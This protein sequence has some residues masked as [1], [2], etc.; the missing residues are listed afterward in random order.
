MEGPQTALSWTCMCVA[1]SVL[2]PFLN[3]GFIDDWNTRKMCSDGCWPLLQFI[4]FSLP[5]TQGELISVCVLHFD[6][7]WQDGAMGDLLHMA[8]NGQKG[9]ALVCAVR[10][11]SVPVPHKACVC[12]R[13][14][15][16]M[17]F[18]FSQWKKRINKEILADISC[19]LELWIH[20]Y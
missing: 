12:E 4:L 16:W 6:S 9:S 7:L 3:S 2:V 5:R 17:Q 15:L 13:V 18:S 10:C 8:M 14:S 1:L 20:Y 19:L 11:W